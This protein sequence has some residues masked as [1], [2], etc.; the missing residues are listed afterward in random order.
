MSHQP[1]S[2]QD[3]IDRIV[4]WSSA[5]GLNPVRVRWKLIR[6]Q[7]RLQREQ[8]RAGQQLGHV[9]YEHKVCPFCGSVQDRQA[10]TCSGC[11]QK[12]PSHAWQVVERLGLV[13]PQLL[14]M[15]TMLG[16]CMLVVYGAMMFSAPGDGYLSWQEPTLIQ[17]GAHYREAVV[18]GQWWRIATAMFVHIGLWHLAFN[19]L[20]LAQVGPSIEQ[21]VGRGRAVFMFMLTGL[22]GNVVSEL[23]YAN[24]IAAG[25]SGAIMGLIGMAAG[26][27]HRDGTTVGRHMRN[28]MLKWG[29]YTMLFGLMIGADNAAHAG[30]F[31]CGLL[32]ALVLRPRRERATRLA[33]ADVAFGVLGTAAALASVAMCFSPSHVALAEE[34]RAALAREDESGDWFGDEGVEPTAHST[35]IWEMCR[36]RACGHHA[37]ALDKMREIYRAANAQPV[38][39]DDRS[40]EELCRAEHELRSMCAKYR[41]GGLE[42]LDAGVPGP[43]RAAVE[44]AFDRMC[45]TYDRAGDLSCDEADAGP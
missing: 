19:L 23:W 34:A 15:S 40:M 13:A 5:L 26:L 42:A 18:A 33:P 17:F 29:A 21:R 3:W 22:A 11:H 4:G 10:R 30:G 32:I 25:A 6:L 39:D 36:L 41:A 43:T 35:A 38:P 20:A 28:H 16:V 27:G 8:R 1:P 45:A 12:L 37:E 24:T 9:R 14:S 44:Q 7:Q 31:V 2:E